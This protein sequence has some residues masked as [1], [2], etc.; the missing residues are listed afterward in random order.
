MKKYIFLF[1]LI[2]FLISSCKLQ[3]NASDAGVSDPTT[4]VEDSTEYKIPSFIDPN[5]HRLDFEQMMILGSN[6]RFTFDFPI[7]DKDGKLLSKEEISKVT[8]QTKNLMDMYANENG[9]VML[10]VIR[11]GSPREFATIKAASL[12]YFAKLDSFKRLDSLKNK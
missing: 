11:P 10:G 5:L 12:K 7:K 4:V 3:N 1:I 6:P 8:Y 2:S 9:K